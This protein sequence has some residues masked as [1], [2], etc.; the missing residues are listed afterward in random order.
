MTTIRHA[1]DEPTDAELDGI[2]LSS[3]TLALATAHPA[4]PLRAAAPPAL[5]APHARA[6]AGPPTV[7]SD[8]DSQDTDGEGARPKWVKN[9]WSAEEDKLLM[10]L[11]AEHGARNWTKI[12]EGMDN[13]AGK[14]CRERWVQHLCPDVKKGAWSA[15][16]DAIIAAEVQRQG[17]R[18]NEIAKLL[19]GRTD[20]AIKNRW[21]SARRKELKQQL[22]MQRGIGLRAKAQRP[23]LH[24]LPPPRHT[25]D[26][27]T[28]G[29]E[30]A[31]APAPPASVERPTDGT[32]AP[33]SKRTRA[34]QP[35]AGAAG[36]S[37]SAPSK[38]KKRA[39][40]TDTRTLISRA[41]AIIL[42]TPPHSA[43]RAEAW[44]YMDVVRLLDCGTAGVA[45]QALVDARDLELYEELA[46]SAADDEFAPGDGPAA[47]DGFLLSPRAEVGAASK[48]ARNKP[49]DAPA[50]DSSPDVFGTMWMHAEAVDGL[51]IALDDPSGIAPSLIRPSPGE[52]R[53]LFPLSPTSPSELGQQRGD[54]ALGLLLPAAHGA[55]Q[56]GV[57]ADGGAAGAG[58]KEPQDEF[59]AGL[60]FGSFGAMQMR[61]LVA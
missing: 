40:A 48:R 14:Q 47:H 3:A 41:K 37:S 59:W 23:L 24:A 4:A 54:V 11:I 51:S 60:G 7:L 22:R 44:R 52:A 58:G 57:A 30:S 29:S 49:R 46:C 35:R 21:N 32:P 45:T 27:T 26:I 33:P 39:G 55:Q 61:A 50:S 10:E 56:L 42:A 53:T 19:T 38:P 31:P 15:E 6:P 13:R 16:E 20:N 28:D 2:R 34:E 8:L 36:A 12:S 17:T 9:P 1:E 43:E 5:D 18:W 25:S